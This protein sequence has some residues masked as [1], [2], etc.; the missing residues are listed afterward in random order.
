MASSYKSLEF[1]YNLSRP[2]GD[3][4][5]SIDALCSDCDNRRY[6][7]IDVNRV[8]GIILSSFVYEGGDGFDMF[9]V[10]MH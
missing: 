7:K 3:R 2:S 5:T 6:E 1:E 10:S 4:V 9:K 8:Y